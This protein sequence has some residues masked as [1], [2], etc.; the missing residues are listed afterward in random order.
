MEAALCFIF[1]SNLIPTKG[2]DLIRLCAHAPNDPRV[3]N[4]LL[5]LG[6]GENRSNEAIFEIF[7]YKKNLNG[8]FFCSNLFIYR[9]SGG[10]LDLLPN[11]I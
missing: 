11:D 7:S 1:V 5:D 8:F 4:Q 10:Q 3:Q 6:R 2:V 9:R